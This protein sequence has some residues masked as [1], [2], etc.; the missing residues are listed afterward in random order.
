LR[1]LAANRL[2]KNISRALP[3]E[4]KGGNRT[5]GNELSRKGLTEVLRA[6]GRCAGLVLHYDIMRAFSRGFETHAN[7]PAMQTVLGTDAR[8]TVVT[9]LPS[10]ETLFEQFVARARSAEYE[11]W[12]D[13]RERMRRFRRRLRA[14]F[15]RLLRWRPKFLKESHLTLLSI[16]ASDAKFEEWISRWEDFLDTVRRSRKNLR[17]VYL[18]PD[19]SRGDHP[20]FR[21]IRS[22]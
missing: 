1:E 2:P 22:V 16:Y 8:I 19:Q 3:L 6:K 20:R 5:S 21:L 4:A 14:A 9:I 15:M 12:W 13:N 11:K 7:D 18:V 10:R 17:L